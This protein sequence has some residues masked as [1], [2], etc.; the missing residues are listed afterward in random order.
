MTSYYLKTGLSDSLSESLSTILAF[1]DS[2]L[3]FFAFLSFFSFY[4]GDASHIELPLERVMGPAWES[5]LSALAL[6]P[7][8]K[9]ALREVAGEAAMPLTL[10]F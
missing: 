3:S 2:F 9:L 7:L 8:S 10:D 4:S 1:L 5:R 6:L